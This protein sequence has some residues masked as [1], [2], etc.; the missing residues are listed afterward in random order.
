MVPLYNLFSKL[1]FGFIPILPAY[2]DSPGT[3]TVSG[4]ILFHVKI[5]LFVTA[6]SNRDPDPHWFSSLIRI[7]IEN[8]ADSESVF[9]VIF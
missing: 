3:G 8:N 2:V 5:Q 4:N 6:R 7:R 1:N 9:Y